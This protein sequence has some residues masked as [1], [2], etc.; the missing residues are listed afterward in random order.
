MLNKA[1]RY[2]FYGLPVLG[3]V[4]AILVI[5]G[6]IV[7]VYFSRI[8]GGL[9]VAFGAYLIT[10]Y[11]VS[12]LIMERRSSRSRL[13]ISRYLSLKGDEQ[14]LD[15]G[16]GLGRTTVLVAKH[17]HEGKVTGVD[18]WDKR[19]I[20]LNSPER[21]YKNAEAE[22]VRDKVEFK[23][24][25]LLKLDFPD[26][27]FDAVTCTFVLNNL[28]KEKRF[29]AVSQIRRVLKPNGKL[30]LIEPLRRPF[31]FFLFSPFVYFNLTEKGT[32]LGLL[33]HVG[34]TKL[35]YTPWNGFGIFS[36]RKPE[37]ERII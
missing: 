9:S 19:Y 35:R 5:A 24:G 28:D 23:H 21:A 29:L 30:L 22:G 7:G 6:V 25:N 3:S 27:S 2:G 15:V 11:F 17:L 26:N 31:M 37:R 1:P 16:C 12:Y 13:D 20:L 10:A 32:W 14:V 33:D 34:F 8:L 36:A 18:I 4:S